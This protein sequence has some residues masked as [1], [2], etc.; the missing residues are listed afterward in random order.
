MTESPAVLREAYLDRVC[1]YCQGIG[2]VE[3][4]PVKRRGRI[5]IGPSRVKCLA[6]EG[7]GKR[8]VMP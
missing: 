4:I 8:Q 3:R 6:C 7:S 5:V 2:Y 1:R